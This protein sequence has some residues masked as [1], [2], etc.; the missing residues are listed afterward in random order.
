[1][2]SY[3]IK[4]MVEKQS[5]LKIVKLIKSKLTNTRWIVVSTKGFGYMVT[6]SINQV[7]FT[8]YEFY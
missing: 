6:P 8:F 2:Q 7:N 5:G 3:F 4:K 1:M